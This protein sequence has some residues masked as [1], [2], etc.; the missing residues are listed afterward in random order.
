MLCCGKLKDCEAGPRVAV[1]GSILSGVWVCVVR[2]EGERC[3]AKVG[4]CLNLFSGCH[5]WDLQQ[6]KC[7]QARIPLTFWSLFAFII[8]ATGYTLHMCPVHK[9][10]VFVALFY[11]LLKNIKETGNVY[12]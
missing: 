4:S 1:L 2:V 9:L 10:Y 3:F 11:V 12:N 7:L 8:V 5:S 6:L